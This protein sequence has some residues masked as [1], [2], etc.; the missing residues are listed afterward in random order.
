[1]F[2]KEED[3]NTKYHSGVKQLKVK[4]RISAKILKYVLYKCNM[5]AN[6]TNKYFF[7]NPTPRIALS[8]IKDHIYKTIVDTCIMYP[9]IIHTC[10][11]V[12]DK[13]YIYIIRTYISQS[14]GSA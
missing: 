7:L 3:I 5:Y 14:Q 4:P 6:K 12:E 1:M 13:K 2:K 10:I 8:G 11:R 9:C